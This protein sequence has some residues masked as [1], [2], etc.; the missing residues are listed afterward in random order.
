[1]TKKLLFIQL[2]LVFNYTLSFGQFRIYVGSGVNISDVKYKNDSGSITPKT[3]ALSNYFLSLRPEIGITKKLSINLDLQYSRKG[4][5]Y[6]D[7]TGYTS[8]RFHYFDLLPQVQYRII[9][10][11]AIYGGCGLSIRHEEYVKPD[12]TWIKYPFETVNSSSVAFLGGIKL[13]PHDRLTIH[14]HLASNPLNH[15]EYTNVSGNPLNIKS[16]INNLQIGLAYR[17]F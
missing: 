13:F 5:K 17:V 2:I 14:A 16:S 11:L 15:V 3:K 12:G 4:F 8:E 7:G 10:L 1:M 9:Q 6:A